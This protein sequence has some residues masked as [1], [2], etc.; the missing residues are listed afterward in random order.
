MGDS[1]IAWQCKVLRGGQTSSFDSE[2]K[3]ALSG[4]KTALAMHLIAAQLLDVDPAI[5]LHVDNE[6]AVKVI[7]SGC[8]SSVNRHIGARIRFLATAHE[9]GKIVVVQ[10]KS[11]DQLADFL[12]KPLVYAALKAIFQRLGRCFRVQFVHGAGAE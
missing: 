6:A 5:R 11:E 2:S 7:R 10:V 1:L 4:V 3:I 9:D 8:V 12:T